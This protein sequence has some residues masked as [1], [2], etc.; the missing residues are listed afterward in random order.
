MVL[1]QNPKMQSFFDVK[2]VD[3]TIH[4]YPSKKDFCPSMAIRF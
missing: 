1:G 2:P 3:K 4:R